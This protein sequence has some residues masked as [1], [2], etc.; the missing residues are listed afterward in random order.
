MALLHPRLASTTV[1]RG[2]FLS[3]YEDSQQPEDHVSQPWQGF[4]LP[5]CSLE[6]SDKCCWPTSSWLWGSRSPGQFLSDGA[7]YTLVCCSHVSG[8]RVGLKGSPLPLR[9]T[10]DSGL[11]KGPH[12]GIVWFLSWRKCAFRCQWNF[13]ILSSTN[14]PEKQMTKK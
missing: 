5:V 12:W 4:S 14:S 8:C 7:E 13:Y 2:G 11:G 6:V 3:S 9:R 1:L 10:N